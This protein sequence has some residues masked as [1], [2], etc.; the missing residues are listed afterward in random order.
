MAKYTIRI[1]YEDDNGTLAITSR[2]D[3]SLWLCLSRVLS[4]ASGDIA[5]LD[6]E[7]AACV[8]DLESRGKFGP[9]CEG[10]AKPLVDG[11]AATL[12]AWRKH[13]EEREAKK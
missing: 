6:E 9:G 3:E 2:E 7:L 13:D 12:N 8:T 10:M 4:G 1:E 11:A 5:R